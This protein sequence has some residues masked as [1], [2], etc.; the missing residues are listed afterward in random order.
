MTE[1]KELKKTLIDKI[2]T[3]TQGGL[4]KDELV[5]VIAHANSLYNFN[6]RLQASIPKSL[7][8]DERIPFDVVYQAANELLIPKEYVEKA[9]TI[10]YQSVEKQLA[11]IRRH[12]VIPS[13][14]TISS[15]YHNALI[16]TLK[17]KIPTDKFTTNRD[18][19]S[20][21]PMFNFYKVIDKEKRSKFL[22][23]EKTKN[24]R[25]YKRL[26]NLQF[27]SDAGNN[28]PRQKFKLNIV[29][30]DPLFLHTCGE[31]LEELNEEFK[32]QMHVYDIRYDY[33]VK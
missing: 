21:H 15:I 7:T 10:R 3:Y 5:D 1:D 13:I 22:F 11:D 32:G 9:L 28:A 31:T 6:E 12:G 30:K 27:Y 20:S 18:D 23:W 16:N 19:N 4:T 2:T 17:A 33:T 29:L 14:G 8:L 24:I 25:S 26:A